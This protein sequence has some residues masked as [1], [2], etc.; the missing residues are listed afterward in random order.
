MNIILDI[1][2]FVLVT[3][4]MYILNFIIGLWEARLS[5]K[6]RRNKNSCMLNFGRFVCIILLQVMYYYAVDMGRFF[7]VSRILLHAIPFFFM[8]CGTKFCV[9]GL[10]GGISCGKS[11]LSGIL[12]TFNQ[13]NIVDADKINHEMMANNV[14]L[15]KEVCA[16]FGAEN[17]LT[18]DGKQIDREKLG[19]IIFADPAKR[20]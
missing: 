14:E 20:Q 15:K 10:T 12:K 7:F 8:Y 9:I 6:I 19:K 18:E 3:L 2:R 1:L 13:F 16:A 5:A 11:T 17:V 4:L